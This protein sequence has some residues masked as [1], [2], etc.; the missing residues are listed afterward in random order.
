LSKGKSLET[1]NTAVLSNF[2]ALALNFLTEVAQIQ[3]Q[4]WEYISTSLFP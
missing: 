3:C 2:P 1:Q 4:Y